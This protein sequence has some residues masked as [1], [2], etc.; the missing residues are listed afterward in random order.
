MGYLEKYLEKKKA[1]ELLPEIIKYLENL[2]R[3]EKIN[4]TKDELDNMLK[5]IND[6]CEKEEIDIQKYSSLIRFVTSQ[7]T[8]GIFKK[9][10][11]KGLWELIYAILILKGKKENNYP[12]SLV[13]TSQVRG[14]GLGYYFESEK[15]SEDEI[16]RESF[17]HLG[18]FYR[19][20]WYGR[21][22]GYLYE[23]NV[24]GVIREELKELIKDSGWDE[25]NGFSIS[26]IAKL[27]PYIMGISKKDKKEVLL[28]KYPN[29]FL[30]S[31]VDYILTVMFLKNKRPTYEDFAEIYV[32]SNRLV[33]RRYYIFPNISEIYEK[34]YS[35]EDDYIIKEVEVGLEGEKEKTFGGS[36]LSRFIFSLWI[37]DPDYE[38]S[39]ILLDKL[40]YYLFNHVR[41][42][43]E[44]LNKLVINIVSY[45]IKKER[46]VIVPYYEYVLKKFWNINIM[47]P[48]EIRLWSRDLGCTILSDKYKN[49]KNL[50]DEKAKK[51]VERILNELK[52][53]NLPGRFFNKIIELISKYELEKYYN[54]ASYISNLL[55]DEKIR[56][57]MDNFFY[58]KSLILF[59][60][61]ESLNR[62]DSC[63]SSQEKS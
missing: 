8:S 38:D 5:E 24:D 21:E 9:L 12:T 53:E 63:K 44:I 34:F 47:E 41:I 17:K 50:D 61:L 42:D 51:I 27:N 49:D 33:N 57:N 14:E 60:L 39:A 13:Y 25:K 62:P 32:I 58:V 55:V 26:D 23:I 43:G 4:I 30:F 29:L 22:E 48:K 3:R 18:S 56:Y 35:S 19:I 6:Y 15:V 40:V 45:S 54:Y 52:V 37:R 28:L 10:K 1:E 59:G 36:K 31:V 11:E 16:K 46:E 2:K 20:Q 7:L